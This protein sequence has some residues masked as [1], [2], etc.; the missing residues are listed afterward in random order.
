MLNYLDFFKISLK[1]DVI[2]Y[3]ARI[4]IV[5][6]FFRC[7]K[8]RYEKCLSVGMDPK[9]VMTQE[10]KQVRFQHYY[11]KKMEK[12][13]R[14]GQPNASSPTPSTST[15]QRFEFVKAEIREGVLPE[16]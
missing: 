3:K 1:R 14:T 5:G 13:K 15:S 10:Q 8:C 4:Q 12:Q 6:Y 7:K 16:K 2:Y 11:K 9:W